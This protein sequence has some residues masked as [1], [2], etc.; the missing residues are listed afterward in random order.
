MIQIKII[1]D[2]KNNN[3]RKVLQRASA[4]EQLVEDNKHQQKGN[5]VELEDD[6]QTFILVK[7]DSK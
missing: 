4:I 2:M 3:F 1:P 5:I 6:E 7:C